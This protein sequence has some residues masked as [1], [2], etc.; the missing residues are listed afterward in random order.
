MKAT[1]PTTPTTMRTNKK[2]GNYYRKVFHK[3][4]VNPLLRVLILKNICKRL[5]L[6]KRGTWNISFMYFACGL[7]YANEEFAYWSI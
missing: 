2:D 6:K 7:Y 1:A 5:L 4:S 3:I